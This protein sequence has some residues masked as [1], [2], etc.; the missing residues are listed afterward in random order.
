MATRTAGSTR[1]QVPT[2]PSRR[3][4]VVRRAIVA[5]AVAATIS[6]GGGAGDGA[7]APDNSV[8]RI[9]IAPNTPQSL[10]SGASASFTA[11]AFTRDGRTV[12]GQTVTWTSSD[13]SIV[14]VAAGIAS[15]RLVGTALISAHVGSISS[16]AVAVSV[17]PGAAAQL[18]M[19]TQP[20]GSVSGGFLTVQPVVE[21]RDAAGNVVPS[22]TLAVTATLGSGGGTL[23]GATTVNAVGGVAT[24][25]SL[26][27]TGTIGPR[28]LMFSAPGVTPVTSAAFALQPGAAAQLVMRTSPSGVTAYTPFTTPAVLELRDGAGNLATSSSAT[29]TATIASGG[30][31]LGGAS[32]VAAAAG[33]A[34][35]S[36][37]TINGGPGP[38]TLPFTG[39]NIPPVTTG[40]FDVAAAAPAVIKLSA[41]GVAVSAAQG[42]VSPPG[43]VNIT[44]GGVVPLTNLRVASI[45]YNPQ[46]PAGWL[47]TQF[48]APDAPSTLRLTAASGTLAVG[49]YTAVVQVAGDGADMSPVP[50]NVTFQ[51]IP[52]LTLKYGQ[53]TKTSILDIGA[54]FAPAVS[55]TNALTGAPETDSTLAFVSRATSVATVDAAGRVTAIAAGETWVVVTSQR[56]GGDSV[57]VIVPRSATAPIL[58]TDLTQ[59][60]FRA[61]DTVD[62][63]I[64]LD[65]RGA[66]RLGAIT[67]VVSWTNDFTS[68]ALTV[69]SV[70]NADSPIHPVFSVDNS[71]GI[72][73]L[74]GA[75]SSGV[76]GP[77]ELL[78]VRFIA[79]AAGRAGWI[80][81][82]ATEML[83]VNFS[84][85]LP[86]ATLTQYPVIVR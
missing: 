61:G 76:T 8:V 24:F 66:T 65:T 56:T 5:V 86:V 4:G 41:A 20:G 49:T 70:T 80:Y 13:S 64:I 42:T 27:I 68:G 16:S 48:S 22:S 67:A 60:T 71:I 73:R 55:V 82:S 1:T 35:F 26:V 62:V 85:L 21:V 83:D 52:A 7:T 23:A 51:V 28:T 79:R 77:I 53:T 18:G 34:T 2:S 15:A 74:T 36:T 29:I 6:C 40:A 45:A 50:L 57:F 33:V 3:R 25:G 84:N 14:S 38:R 47:V 44:N 78:H 17:T 63:R 39:P 11:S 54:T 69:N 81:L 12:T 30:G 37:L 75:S 59:F 19:R 58:R 9:D 46:T 32:S 10:V 72:I 43:T 31:V